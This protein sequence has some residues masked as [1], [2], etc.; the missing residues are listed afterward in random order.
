MLLGELMNG[1]ELYAHNFLNYLIL[2][3]TS[4]LFEKYSRRDIGL[5]DLED[6]FSLGIMAIW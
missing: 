6:M 4:S 1:V 2:R 5:L 3:V